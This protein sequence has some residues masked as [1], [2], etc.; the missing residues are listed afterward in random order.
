QPVSAT[1]MRA[2][3]TQP[4]TPPLTLDEAI[5]TTKIHSI[6][7][8]LDAEQSFVSRRPFRA[9]HHAIS[10]IGA[11][12]AG[13]CQ[14]RGEVIIAHNGVLFRDELPEFNRSA[15]EVMR[16]PLEDGK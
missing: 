7:G 14:T 15:W 9:P 11:L 4:I 8:L 3:R 2:T 6:A 5:E 10:D 1:S 12:G 13:A 16:Q